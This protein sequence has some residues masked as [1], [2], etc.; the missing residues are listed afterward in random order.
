MFAAK[1]FP[2]TSAARL[3]RS[4]RL[5]LARRFASASAGGGDAQTVNERDKRSDRTVDSAKYKVLPGR[6][7]LK[8]AVGQSGRR[9][10]TF[11][12]VAP[13]QLAAA[14]VL[15]RALSARQTAPASQVQRTGRAFMR[16]LVKLEREK[17]ALS[18]RE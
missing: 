15:E 3:L 4:R 16:Q 14:E 7:G 5:R 2:V 17:R 18:E 6:R 9:S 8:R 11:H 10:G 13:E 12:R 1:Q